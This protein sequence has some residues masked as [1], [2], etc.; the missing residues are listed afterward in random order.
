MERRTRRRAF[1]KNAVAYTHL[2]VYKRQGA[3]RG[4]ETEYA[5]GPE[6]G[7]ENAGTPGEAAMPGQAAPGNSALGGAA[8]GEMGRAGVDITGRGAAGGGLGG[9]LGAGLAAVLQP[10]VSEQEREAVERLYDAG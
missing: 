6:G 7:G 10:E 3:D 1:V 4:A 5:G 8:A 2:D 9:A